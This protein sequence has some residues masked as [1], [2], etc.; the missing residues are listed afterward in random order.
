MHIGKLLFKIEKFDGD[1]SE[2]VFGIIT[3][4]DSWIYNN[5]TPGLNSNQVFGCLTNETMSAVVVSG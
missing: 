1:Y 2:Q 4:Y 5:I 3:V